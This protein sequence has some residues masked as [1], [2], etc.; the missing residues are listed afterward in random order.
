LRG[1][2]GRGEETPG[3]IR[4]TIF[5]R[6]LKEVEGGGLGSSQCVLKSNE[7]LLKKVQYYHSDGGRLN[8]TN[9]DEGELEKQHGVLLNT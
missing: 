5:F 4:E 3:K 1:F 2:C 9:M 7:G 8:P 6:Y